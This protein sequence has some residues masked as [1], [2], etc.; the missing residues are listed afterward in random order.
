[1]RRL[2]CPLGISHARQPLERGRRYRLMKRKLH[3]GARER[4]AGWKL[5]D[6]LPGPAVDPVG[7]VKL[8]RLTRHGPLYD[9]GDMIVAGTP[10]R[11]SLDA[12]R[13]TAQVTP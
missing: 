3:G 6:I 9:T 1:M 11:L 4:R 12:R 13:P 7:F 2:S 10:I 5:R 8:W